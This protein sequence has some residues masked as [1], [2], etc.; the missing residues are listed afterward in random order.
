MSAYY[1]FYLHKCKDI[2]VDSAEGVPVV[3]S[4]LSEEQKQPYH[5]LAE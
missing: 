2:R 3:W 4:S 1:L 5:L